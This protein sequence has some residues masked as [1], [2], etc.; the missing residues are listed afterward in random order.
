MPMQVTSNRNQCV[1]CNVTNHTLV[2]VMIMPRHEIDAAGKIVTRIQYICTVTNIDFCHFRCWACLG[3]IIEKINVFLLRYPGQGN[4]VS[5]R[6][7]S[8]TLIFYHN[9]VPNKITICYPSS[10]TFLHSLYNVQIIVGLQIHNC[11]K[12]LLIPGFM[13]S[14]L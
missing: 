3:M 7:T 5:H 14:E 8:T 11:P 10:K 13:L 4:V 6:I 12:L 9:I 2:F 1:I